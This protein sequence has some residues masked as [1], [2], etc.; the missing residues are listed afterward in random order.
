MFESIS[1]Q[2]AYIQ[3]LY[4]VVYHVVVN[5][6]FLL[7]IVVIAIGVILY[8]NTK[9]NSLRQFTMNLIGRLDR[10]ERIFETKLT[11]QQK[12]I[13]FFKTKIEKLEKSQKKLSKKKEKWVK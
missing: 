8:R 10:E 2:I 9:L 7:M 1:Q 3:L 13:R 11:S 12:E 4:Y 6:F 5:P